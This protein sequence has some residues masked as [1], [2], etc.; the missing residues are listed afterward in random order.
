MEGMVI[1]K[2]MTPNRSNKIKRSICPL[3]SNLCFS[4]IGVSIRMLH[5]LL[6]WLLGWGFLNRERETIVQIAGKR[7][8]SLMMRAAPKD[9]WGRRGA[10]AARAAPHS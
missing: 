2:T 3:N 10:R 4:A 6:S 9:A 7:E 1:R 5:L 8:K